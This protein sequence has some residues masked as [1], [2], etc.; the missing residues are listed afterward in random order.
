MKFVVLLVSAV[1]LLTTSCASITSPARMKKLEPG[2]SYW[3]DYDASRRGMVLAMTAD[4]QGRP[5]ARTCAEP[6]PDVA[7]QVAATASLEVNTPGATSGSAGASGAQAAKLLSERTQMVMFFREALFRVCEIS[8]NQ[9]LD[10]AHVVK[11]Y[12]HIINT[13]LK[14]GSDKAFDVEVLQAKAELE[15]RVEQRAEAARKVQALELELAA[16]KAKLDREKIQNQL[17]IAR[18]SAQA[19]EAGVLKA[20]QQL[21]AIGPPA[22]PAVQREGDQVT[23]SN[24]LP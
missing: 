15:Q 21:S 8:L 20:A 11:L 3:F 14:L 2:H 9:N 22:V 16:T 5:V 4:A 12:E 10:S 18:E 17:E 7:M 19:A 24:P 13:A 6:A 23:L 1:A